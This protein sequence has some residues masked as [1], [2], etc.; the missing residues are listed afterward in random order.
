MIRLIP[1]LKADQMIERLRALD[2]A[3]FDSEPVL[4]EIETQAKELM[5][6]YQA[7]AWHVLGI[8]AAHRRD[9]EGVKRAFVNALAR[10]PGNLAFEQNYCRALGLVG[11]YSD[12]MLRAI[13]LVE[14]D[15]ADIQFIGETVTFAIGAGAFNLAASVNAK[16]R[17]LG[18]PVL[19]GVNEIAEA[20][21]SAHVDDKEV[22]ARA[23]AV[24]ALLRNQN[25]PV[26]HLQWNLCGEGSDL[27]Y[28]VRAE[29]EIVAEL[30]E[31][32]ADELCA[33]FDDPL[34]RTIVFGCRPA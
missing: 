25:I 33:K 28:V 2:Q 14:R 22:Q 13:P 30:N 4:S 10:N 6:H 15:P 7:D 3:A 8:V 11:R 26:A 1:Q 9:D 12:A 16:L 19:D 21:K 17:K 20:I 29:P 23:E 31:Q 32:I 18:A 27:R 34:N 5:K 24:T